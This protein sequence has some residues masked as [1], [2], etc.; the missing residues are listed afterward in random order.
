MSEEFTSLVPNEISVDTI[1]QF[2][3]FID[4]KVHILEVVKM[5]LKYAR[6]KIMIEMIIIWRNVTQ[7]HHL[8]IFQFVY[9]EIS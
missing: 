2:F 9:D 4:N 1:Y 3:T 8:R 5:K 7:M 6:E